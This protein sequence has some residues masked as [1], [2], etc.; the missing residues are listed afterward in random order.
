M[1]ELIDNPK[2]EVP[3]VHGYT[4]TNHEAVKDGA[5]PNREPIYYK[6]SRSRWRRV[7][8][9]HDARKRIEQKLQNRPET[10]A[11][12]VT[13]NSNDEKQ[14][15]V[16]IYDNGEVTTP[17]R[18]VQQIEDAIPS[19][20]T[21][22]A[23]R[24]T[25]ME[26]SVR[27][28]PVSVE[29]ISTKSATPRLQDDEPNYYWSDWDEI[30]AGSACKVA[31]YDDSV[32]IGFGTGTLCTPIYHNGTTKMLTAGHNITAPGISAQTEWLAGKPPKDESDLV[33]DETRLTGSPGPDTFDAATLGLES[34][35]QV[36]YELARG[37]GMTANDIV[38]S[39]S[40]DKLKDIEDDGTMDGE[41]FQRQGSRTGTSSGFGID[42]IGS[43]GFVTTLDQDETDQGDSGGPYHLAIS[44]MRASHLVGSDM[45]LSPAEPTSHIAG[46]HQGNFVDGKYTAATSMY[47]IEEEFGVT[48]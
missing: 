25:M 15:S 28:I 37:N 46:V 39:I 32:R 6:I 14:I 44:P 17:N 48:V 27:D 9:A 2:R 29:R 21:G 45:I 3:R 30:P 11:V 4:H 5:S 22:V 42:K 13:T 40:E 1:A 31:L 18:T 19:T 33:P 20:I 35:T 47:R 10:I 24:G 36:T 38:G 23:G 43:D 26:D 41:S 16:N 7:E 8:S 34:D 12:W